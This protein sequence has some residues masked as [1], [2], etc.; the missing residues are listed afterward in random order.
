[1]PIR[2]SHG[3]TDE[4]LFSINLNP[5]TDL[6]RKKK[7]TT[8][9]KKTN[10]NKKNKRGRRWECEGEVR[11]VSDGKAARNNISYKIRAKRKPGRTCGMNFSDM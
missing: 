5:S 1:M 11:V 9:E 4:G 10:K 7:K 2:V 6:K 8:T 3:S